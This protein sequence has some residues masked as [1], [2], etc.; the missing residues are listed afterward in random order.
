MRKCGCCLKGLKTY[1]NHTDKMSR[2]GKNRK[3]AYSNN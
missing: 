1:F 3:D 2:T